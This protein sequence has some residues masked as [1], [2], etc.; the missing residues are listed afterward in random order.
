MEKIGPFDQASDGI[1]YVPADE[2][3]IFY[4]EIVIAEYED[5]KIYK[6]R[7]EIPAG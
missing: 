1:F 4:D 2:F 6:K 3:N 5:W 7:G